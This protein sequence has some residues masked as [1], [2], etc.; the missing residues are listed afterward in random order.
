[1][2]TEILKILALLLFSGTKILFAPGAILA[3]GY[4]KIETILIAFLGASAGSLFFLKLGTI[5][6]KWFEK[7]FA[8]KKKKKVFTQKNKFIVR[9][10]RNFGVIG[11]ALII[12]IISIPASAIISAK[13][14]RNDPK[15]I[16]AFIGSSILWAVTLTFF[17]EPI[18]HFLRSL[19]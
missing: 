7:M 15:T 17:S 13:Y 12:P 14:F 9:F 16:P 2:W 4:G 8:S 11:M 5:L 19:F 10:K 6:F 18:I 3:A 1:M